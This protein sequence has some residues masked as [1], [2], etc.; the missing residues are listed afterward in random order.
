[1]N[2][3]TPEQ[4]AMRG[5]PPPRKILGAGVHSI[6]ADAYHADPAPEPSLSST[7]ARL[8][9]NR[10]PLHAWTESPRLNPAWEPTDSATFDI[11]R[12]AHRA[13]L[14]AG[15]DYVAYPEMLLGAGGAASTKAAKEWAEEQR[16]AGRTPLKAEVVD[17]VGAM[18]DVGRARLAA[19]N[20]HLAPTRSEMTALAEIDGVWCRAMIDNAPVDSTLPLID[21]KTCE[22]AT[23]EACRRSIE[24]YGY[25]MQAAHYLDVWEKA[26]GERR[27][28][29]FAFQEKAAP[30]S[31]TLVRLLDSPGHSEDWLEDAREKVA[32]ARVMWRRCLTNG[33]WPDYPLV[34]TELGASPYHR[35]KWQD[36]Q[37]RAAQTAVFSQTAINRAAAWQSPE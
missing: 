34:I 29:I 16:A 3:M 15:G 30:Y 23:P 33:V 31:M 24:M 4:R 10:S 37:S 7:L 6:P 2:D 5:L 27:G 25:D 17:A 35:Q 14:G 32:S 1:M 22:N 12:A 26:T 21:F 18:A 9:V 8:I 28:F 20:L 13:L 19:A 36:Q 11:G